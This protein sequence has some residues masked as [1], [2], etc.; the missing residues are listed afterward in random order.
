MLI[1]GYPQYYFYIIGIIGIIFIIWKPQY[2]LWLAIFY[3]SARDI[4]TAALT[5]FELTG[6]Y[7]NLDDFI[8]IILLAS[9]FKF[10]F[11]N[12]IKIPTP[13]YWLFV[14]F[15][16]SILIIS[17]KYSLTYEV[18]REHKAALYFTLAFFSSY[19]LVKYERDFELVLKLLFIGSV[20]ASIQYIFITQE[21]IQLWGVVNNEESF[22]SVGFIGLIPVFIITSFFLK[23]KWLKSLPSKLFFLTGLSLMLVNLILSQTRSIYISI[24][25]TVILIFLLQKEIKIKSGILLLII[26]PFLVY[27][28][29]DQYLNLLNI[30]EVLF[31]RVQL[32][33]D[34]PST[35][36]TTIGRLAALK[37]EFAAF[38]NSNIIFGNGLGFTYFLPE[39]YNPYIAWGHI[40]HIAYLARLGLLGFIIYSIYIP[41]TSLNYF[42]KID[43]NSLKLNYTKIFILFGTAVIINDWIGFWMSAS[44]LGLTAFLPGIVIGITWALR[45][46]KII[47]V[48][49]S[50][51]KNKNA[52]PENQHSYPIV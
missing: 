17:L 24:I 43:P 45:D 22:R 32:L 37:Y 16:S 50:T 34:N 25:L 4:R 48:K 47:L 11:D 7:L 30:N 26:I 33:S 38:L 51:Q 40:G 35:D 5:R 27:I 28:I 36:L 29:F 21:K 44:Y 1:E 42:Y 6:P 31:G 13:V 12:K 46:K 9:I 52:I 23:L 39:A 18:Q 14:C 8:I 2:N 41:L 20:V 49:Y 10:S 19:N 3:F 15:L